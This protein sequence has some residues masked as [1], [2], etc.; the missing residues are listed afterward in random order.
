MI[1]LLN[2]AGLVF[3][4]KVFLNKEYIHFFLN[5][6]IFFFFFFDFS[7]SMVSQ[8]G[9]CS[10]FIICEFQTQLEEIFQE[11]TVSPPIIGG[12]STIRENC[13]LQ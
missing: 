13:F 8:Y 1:P 6:N 5:K 2:M 3:E 10:D 11:L 12:N 9:I 4:P 7:L